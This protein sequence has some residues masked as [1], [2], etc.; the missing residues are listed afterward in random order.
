MKV[1][2]ST[3]CTLKYTSKKKV[4]LLSYILKEY[5]K[6]VNFYIDY[7]WNNNLLNIDRKE[8]LKP[9]IDLPKTWLSARL[10]KVAARESLSL[11]HS[12]IERGD[13]T[14]PFHS[15]K[16]MHI[17][18]TIGEL[19]N[20]KSKSFDCWLQLRCIG[21]KFRLD[22]PIKLHKH[23]NI[24][25][26]A[27]KRLNSYIITKDYIQF[28]FKIIKD[29]KKQVGS[30][31][32]VDTGINTLAALSNGKKYGEKVKSHIESIKRCK[33]GSKEQKRR[34]RSLKQ[35]IDETVKDIYRN[36][37]L[38]LIVVENLKNLNKNT[39]SK[40]RLAKNIRRSI[41]IW[42]YHY[43]LNRLR[44]GSEINRVSFRSIDPSYT[45]QKCSK[46]GH[47]H[48]RNRNKEDFLC[49]SCGHK[50]NA[51]LNA[52]KNILDRFLIGPYGADF[53]PKDWD[54]CPSF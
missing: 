23:F 37:D 13:T 10:R 2:R 54:I 26:A 31:V 30:M 29:R 15:G 35:Y 4:K 49:L 7:F 24:L 43:W 53:K 21:R 46:C 18:S 5:S 22:I 3:K 40:R 32:G 34:R 16:S 14:K 39:K 41:G 51:D 12:V 20:S 42:N 28:S 25:S 52:S 27:G 1:I 9:I 19:T 44:Q 33:Y 45:S 38:K 48:R 47:T 36:E 6:T 50:D 11:I 8:L 17:S